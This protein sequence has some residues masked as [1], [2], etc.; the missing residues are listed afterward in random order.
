MIYHFK[1]IIFLTLLSTI[2]IAQAMPNI[3]TEV[4]AVTNVLLD[5]KPD[6]KYIY[7]KK[8]TTSQGLILGGGV[9]FTAGFIG[10]NYSLKNDWGG[11]RVFNPMNP[12][13]LAMALGAVTL[14]IGITIRL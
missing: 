10:N 8:I 12:N 7:Q 5:I 14:T 9:L 11:P 4:K 3:P 13:Q 6:P 2:S 1:L